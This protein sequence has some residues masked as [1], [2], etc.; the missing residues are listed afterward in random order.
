MICLFFIS[1]LKSLSKILVICTLYF[2]TCWNILVVFLCSSKFTST[3]CIDLGVWNLGVWPLELVPKELKLLCAIQIFLNTFV[4]IVELG[5]EGSIPSLFCGTGTYCC[6][7][8][9]SRSKSYILLL[10]VELDI[11]APFWEAFSNVPTHLIY[12]LSWERSVVL[13]SNL[14]D[15]DFSFCLWCCCCFLN[16]ST[17]CWRLTCPSL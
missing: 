2:A 13:E 7:F 9:G 8:D 12:A 17:L 6:T 5:L 4:P 10:V 1:R 3:P 11:L 15:M 14:G 16:N